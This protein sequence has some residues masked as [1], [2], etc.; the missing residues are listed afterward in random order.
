MKQLK[1]FKTS[2]W[3]FTAALLAV[4]IAAPSVLAE[5]PKR[6]SLTAAHQALLGDDPVTFIDTRTNG[7]WMRATTMLPGALRVYTQDDL[8]RVMNE[9]PK[10]QLIIPY[11]T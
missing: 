9:L 8:Q 3:L 11:C 7:Q 5:S 4:L 2:A 6:I 10:D 1:R